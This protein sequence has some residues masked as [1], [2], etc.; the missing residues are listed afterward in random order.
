MKIRTNVRAGYAV[1]RCGGST[2]CGGQTRCG[3]ST[4]CSGSTTYNLA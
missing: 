3:G 1:D 2:R 4:R